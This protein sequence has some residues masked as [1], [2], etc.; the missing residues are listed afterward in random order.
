M[1]ACL[2]GHDNI[3]RRLVRVEGIEYQV[4]DS[5]GNTALQTALKMKH[6]EIAEVLKE[7][8]SKDTK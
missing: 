5:S 3:V 7:A 4:R 8:I 6:A 2:Q 1:L